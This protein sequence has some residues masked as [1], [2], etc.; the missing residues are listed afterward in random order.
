MTAR[1]PFA[2]TR[3]LSPVFRRFPGFLGVNKRREIDN[4][5]GSVVRSRKVLPLQARSR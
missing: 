2:R 4:E 5:D 3:C 1:D